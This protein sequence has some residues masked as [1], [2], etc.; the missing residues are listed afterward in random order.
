MRQV[1][2]HIPLE[3]SWLPANFPFYLFVLLVGV[4]LSLLARLGSRLADDKRPVLREWL[5]SFSFTVFMV[6]LLAAGVVLFLHERMPDGI[7]I[8]GFGMMLFLAFLT[9]TWQGGRWAEREGIAR[10]HIQDL[11]IWV[12]I[13]GLIGARLTYIYTMEVPRPSLIEGL[14]QLPRIWEG[15][16]VLYGSVGGALVAYLFAY[17]FLF[18]RHRVSTLRLADAVAPCIAIGLC[19][20]RIGCFLNGCCYGQV[21]CPNSPVVPVHFPIMSLAWTELVRDGSQTAAGFTLDP[22]NEV[23]PPYGARVGQVD[24]ASPA[25]A[26]GLRPGDVIIRVGDKDITS[27]DGLVKYIYREEDPPG[28]RTSV[29]PRGETSLSLT[30]VHPGPDAEAIQLPPFQPRTLGLHPTQLYESISMALLLLLLI[31]YYPFRHRPGQVM[32]VLMVGYSIHRMLNEMLRFDRRPTGIE[33]YTSV[34][35]CAAG[36]GMWLYLQFKP[37][38]PEPKEKK[39]ASMQPA[40]A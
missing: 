4:G 13:G 28:D 31:A 32:A 40:G 22:R 2:F 36:V 23:R 8:Y 10:E 5:R 34:I 11:A 6:G 30:V 19:L 25:Y 29:L 1:L 35:L 14:K 27:S 37:A 15:G 20:G 18:R 9:C 26:A 12:F 33:W 17:L 16:I 21:A 3:V 38:V 7:P 24:P 39:E